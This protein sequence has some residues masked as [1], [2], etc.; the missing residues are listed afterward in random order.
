MKV[1]KIKQY[2][3]IPLIDELVYYLKK[4]AL[5][6]ILKDQEEADKYETEKSLRNAHQ[7]IACVE[8]R[9]NFDT[10]QYTEN[11]LKMVSIPEYLIYDCMAD[12]NKIPHNFKDA[13]VSLCSERCLNN[14][15]E[16]NNYYRALNG[17]PDIGDP[18]IY[19]TDE[20]IPNEIKKDINPKIVLH[21]M[22]DSHLE[23]LYEYEVI[24]RLIT[25]YPNKKYLNHLGYRSIDVYNARKANRFALLYTVEDV[26]REVLNR[27]KDKI[28][29]NRVFTIKTIYNDAFKLESDYY[30]KFIMTFIIIQTL[31]DIFAEVPDMIIKKE[32]FDIRTVELIFKC[33]GVDFFPEIPFKY[34]IAMI[35]NI[36]R[37]IKYKST[38][39][40]IVDICSLFGFDNIKVFKY[41]LLKDRKVD[42][43]GEYE[44]HYKEEINKDTGE[45]ELVEDDSKN[46]ELKF[47][48]VPI[49]DICDNYIHD[50]TKQ[51]DYDV[52][53]EGDKY[54]DGDLPHE[55]V[56]KSILDMEFNYLQS[57]YL[58]VDTV[59]S[60]TEMSFQ[61]IYFYNMLFDNVIVEEKL[62]L[63]APILSN[64]ANFKLVDII[65]YLYALM[66]EYNGIK[67]DLM[68]TPTKIMYI[69]GFN[70]NAD[71]TDLS[72]YI[73]Q[74]GFTMKELGIEEFQI[75]KSSVLSYKQ[76]MHIFTTNKNIHDHIVHQLFTADNKRIYDVYYKIY[77]S[78]M[79][80]EL[81]MEFFRKKDGSIAKTYT[82][83]IRDRDLILYNALVKIKDIRNPEL[84]NE[85]ISEQI[86]N[87]IYVLEEYINT[88]KFKFIF[89]SLPSVSAEAIKRYIFKVINFFKSYKVDILGIGTIYKFDDKLDNKIKMIDEVLFKHVF[90]KEEF[91]KVIDRFKERYSNF[92]IKDKCKIIDELYMQITYWVKILVDHDLNI[93]EDIEQIASLLYKSDSEI[94]DNPND[95]ISLLTFDKESLKIL[96]NLK[97]SINLN[98]QDKIAFTDIIYRYI[99]YWIGLDINEYKYELYSSA[100]HNNN[101]KYFEKLKILDDIRIIK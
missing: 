37:L 41:Y 69:K 26:P 94:F 49:D 50:K 101:M 22:S 16:L 8:N 23:L 57:K 1:K 99:T 35:R 43:Y 46:Y 36:N 80:N 33:H 51:I 96:D 20:Y 18:G 75:P 84:K 70:F 44:F 6:T 78:L 64:S 32:I 47:I 89:S 85:R 7:Y 67:D 81:S 95:I 54:W 98:K 39:K 2:D 30:D 56:R 100:I 12:R 55:A 79:I 60:L 72:N 24:D 19:L 34:Q 97:K 38:T 53:T 40:N 29:Q 14:Y 86:N 4:L 9:A 15:V 76:L 90:T 3:S 17:L 58:S 11:D 27:Y 66:Y 83:F 52:I 71:M 61:L 42:K 73:Y 74:K 5:S 10:F 92:T 77:E 21:E 87:I 65:C 88:D 28:E 45:V 68:D 31:I 25:K 93:K 82:E 63:N 59:Y 48:K 91:I 13:L 62:R